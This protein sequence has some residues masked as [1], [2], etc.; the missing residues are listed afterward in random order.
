MVILIDIGNTRIKVARFNGKKIL[1]KKTLP[2]FPLTQKKIKKV[3]AGSSVCI[4]SSVVPEATKILR[5][6]CN[7]E[8]IKFHCFGRRDLKGILIKYDKR[9]K[10]GSDR[11]AT[12]MGA[13]ALARA[14]FII[15]DIGTAVTCEL[16]NGKKEY[17]G[18]IIFPGVELWPCFRR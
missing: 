9:S 4:C 12:I 14:P 1:L 15:V 18:G 16:V 13:A 7:R 5:K 3:L 6:V 17:V 2:T 8:K 10:I 11:L